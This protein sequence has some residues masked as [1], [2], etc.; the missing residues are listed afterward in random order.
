[1]SCTYSTSKVYNKVNCFGSNGA[2][3]CPFAIECGK[4]IA[5]D[6]IE[7]YI[8]KA[9]AAYE[10][11]EHNNTNIDELNKAIEVLKAECDRHEECTECIFGDLHK[12]CPIWRTIQVWG[13]LKEQKNDCDK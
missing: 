9:I 10:K 1:M 2:I 8:R 4:T 5:W 7:K 3:P 6:S 11:A 13:P 12:G